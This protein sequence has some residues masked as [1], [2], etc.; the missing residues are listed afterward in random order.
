MSKI[1]VIQQVYKSAKWVPFVYPA[2][3]KQTFQDFTLYVQIVEDDGGA[4]EYIQ[5]HC[6]QA[7]ILEPGYNIGFT[8]GHNEIFSSTDHDFYQLVNPDLILEPTYLEEVIKVFNDPKVGAAT[9]KIL[10]FD[11]EK[12]EKTKVIDTTGVIIYKTGRARDRGQLEIDT[13]QYDNLPNIAA[14]C[15][16][17]PMYRKAA[18]DAV[19]YKNRDGRTEYFDETFHSY[20]ED[21][22]LSWRMF[23][24]GFTLR[25]APQALAYHGRTAGSSKNGYKDVLG[26]IRHHAKISPWIRRLNFRNHIY[27]Y[28]KNT[29]RFYW[30]FF[31]REFFMLGY[32]ILFEIKTLAIVPSLMRH[33]PEMW[34]KRKRMLRQRKI[35]QEQA[36]SIFSKHPTEL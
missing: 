8:K 28:I 1:G 35:T 14:I 7:R 25:Y 24:A 11:F 30:K 13:G 9:G 15:G 4:K 32:I 33:V 36:E 10:R 6:P 2:L 16:C 27:L 12:K 34:Q 19:A 31:A 5:E 18:L 17:S 3:L 21:V 23:N 26:F 29:P 20:W 22:D